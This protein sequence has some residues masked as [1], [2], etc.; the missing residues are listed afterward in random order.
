MAGRRKDA[1]VVVFHNVG[2]DVRHDRSRGSPALLKFFVE[3]FLGTLVNDSWGAYNAVVCVLRHACL[4]HLSRQLEH[5]EN[6]LAS[7]N[8]GRTTS[9]RKRTGPRLPRICG[10][11]WATPCGCGGGGASGRKRRTRRGGVWRC[12]WNNGPPRRGR[13]L[14]RS[15][16]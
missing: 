5:R 10:V 12:A 13:T 11:C 4:V 1:L 8:R 7:W 3:E 15:V 6:F 9:R 2:F 14:T 16:W